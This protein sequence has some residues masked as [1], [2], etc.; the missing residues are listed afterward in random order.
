MKRS[1]S[2]LFALAVAAPSLARAEDPLTVAPDPGR[3][4]AP[5]H[6][7]PWCGAV[8]GGNEYH[9][10][11]VRRGI[12]SAMKYWSGLFQPARDLCNAKPDDPEAQK[13][14]QVI[15]Q[16][17]INI[18]GLPDKDAVASLAARLDEEKLKADKVKLCDQIDVSDEVLGEERAFV[19]AKRVLFGCAKKGWADN[20]PMWADSGE[21]LPDDL[22]FFLDVSAGDPD[23]L[24]RLASVLQSVRVLSNKDSDYFEKQLAGTYVRDQ[25]DYRAVN[26][27]AV[28][29]L[30]DTPPYKGNL[31]ARTIGLESVGVA[32]AGID[33]VE[34][35]VKKRA[36]KDP[37]WK[38]FLVTAPERG[39]AEWRAS[40]AKWK[41]VLARS[42]DFER[43]YF[44]PS[45]RAARGCLA[46]LRGDFE[47]VAKTLKHDSAQELRESL[48]DPVA[49]LLYQRMVLC[50]SIDD[51]ANWAGQL[52]AIG[53]DVRYARGP[54]VAAYWAS[55]EAL[56]KILAD[57]ERFPV[58]MAD[59][60]LFKDNTIYDAALK[61]AADS[62][63]KQD[64]MGY[65]GDSGNGV[66]A[67]V[68][69]SGGGVEVAFVKVRHQEM[70]YSCTDTNHVLAIRPN[71]TLVYRQ[72]CKQTGLY[73]VDNTPGA[74]TIP[75]A[76]AGGVTPG[77]WLE[78]KSERGKPP[79]RRALPVSVYA[80]KSKKKLV[81]WMGLGF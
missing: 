11:G 26:L 65:V 38:E 34:A 22:P 28:A 71:G 69:K 54:R 73:W 9:A 59:M 7:A 80:D 64:P 20:Q 75:A 18:T 24:V 36:S 44:G 61:E 6:A 12:E 33:A 40:A 66:V 2:V 30:L 72:N 23:E 78:F 41:D 50:I 21:R 10:D 35:E 4:K 52:R 17:W 15:E 43:K 16:M 13:Q 37:D 55:V 70:G 45:K 46:G 51:D 53:A 58:K 3:D 29:K 32:R 56:G 39:V 5:V 25:V 67:T 77:R 14:V 27:D 47:K 63:N 68:K 31:W 19:T 42:N 60:F 1:L 57:R 49:S 62:K 79:T 8:K 81:N 76:W 48:S 74:I